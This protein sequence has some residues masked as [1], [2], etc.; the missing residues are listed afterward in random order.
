MHFPCSHSKNGTFQKSPGVAPPYAWFSPFGSN[1]PGVAIE[2]MCL[3]TV[4]S[5][6]TASIPIDRRRTPLYW[7]SLFDSEKRLRHMETVI[8]AAQTVKNRF[9]TGCHRQQPDEKHNSRNIFLRPF[10]EPQ[11]QPCNRATTA[12]LSMTKPRHEDGVS[13]GE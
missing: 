12:V 13:M 9:A 8:A 7:F 3:G 2:A 6:N 1:W 4:T 10:T 5:D 11:L